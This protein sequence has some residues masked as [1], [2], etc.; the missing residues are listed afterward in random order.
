MPISLLKRKTNLELQGID[1]PINSSAYVLDKLFSCSGIKVG[2]VQP[3]LVLLNEVILAVSIYTF[4]AKH[5]RQFHEVFREKMNCS[6]AKL[7]LR[8]HA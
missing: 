3:K 4:A 5:F 7:L 8:K 1:R 6:I 2:V